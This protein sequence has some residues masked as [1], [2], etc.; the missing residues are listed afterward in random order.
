MGDYRRVGD[1]MDMLQSEKMQI[2]RVGS[3]PND[4]T[5]T[6]GNDLG[7][8]FEDEVFDLICIE[9]EHLFSQGV[10]VFHTPRSG[11]G[12]KDI[13]VTSNV[14]LSFLNQDF[15]LKG[16]ERIVIYIECKSSEQYEV[17]HDKFSSN[18]FSALEAN[19][20]YFV[21][22]TNATISPRSHWCTQ[23]ELERSGIDFRLVDRFL[24]AM[25]FTQRHS[26]ISGFDLKVEPEATYVEYQCRPTVVDGRNAFKLY[27]VCRNYTETTR[28]GTLVLQTD[29]GWDAVDG[30]N[31]TM[32]KHGCCALETTIV[33]SLVED[34]DEVRLKVEIGAT[35]SWFTLNS[36]WKHVFE[37][38]F[39]GRDKELDELRT[40]VTEASGCSA[41]HLFG[42]AGI[43]KSRLIS[44]AYQE[45]LGRTYDFMFLTIKRSSAKINKD[46][47]AFLTSK[48]YL[49]QSDSGISLTHSIHSSRNKYR[50]AIIVV[51][52]LHNA[53]GDFL[54]EVE[55]VALLE[56]DAPVG[57]L[58]CGR[59]DY[60]AFNPVY[61][62]HLRWCEDFNVPALSVPKLAPKKTSLLVKSLIA[63]VPEVVHEKICQL[64]NN[65]PL[66][67]VQFVEYLLEERIATI[68]GRNTIGITNINA[69]NENDYIPTGVEDI[70][71]KRLKYLRGLPEKDEVFDFLL[72]LTE[73]DG[74]L[75][76][77]ASIDMFGEYLAVPQFLEARRIIVSNG[78][79]YEFVHESM[80][81]FFR[82]QLLQTKRERVRVA[83]LVLGPRYE[84]LAI[85]NDL[86]AGKLCYWR[87]DREKARLHFTPYVERLESIENVS[88]LRVD[89]RLFEYLPT[90]YSYLEEEQNDI[91]ILKKIL[92]T[93]VYLAL[94][95]ISPSKAITE[96]NEALESIARNKELSADCKIKHAIQAQK[97][98]ALMM[99]GRTS[100]GEQVL[101][102][103]LSE[104]LLHPDR[105][106][107]EALFDIFDRLCV[108]SMKRN[109]IAPAK[110]Y[111]ELSLAI[112]KRKKDQSLEIIAH[113]TRTKLYFYLSKDEARASFSFVNRTIDGESYDR[114]K[115]CNEIA[116][117]I[118][119]LSF[120]PALCKEA[121]KDGDALLAHAESRHYGWAATRAYLLLA[122]C[123]YL[124]RSNASCNASK[125][126]ISK[127]INAC[128]RFSISD[129]IWQFYNL[130]G[131][132]DTSLD[133]EIAQ[134][135][136]V[137]LT[138]Y[139][140]LKHQKLLW[141]GEGEFCY[142]S[143][144][145]LN[146][147]GFF[148]ASKGL[149]TEFFD[150]MGDIV[151]GYRKEC[152]YDCS[153][154]TC[155]FVCPANL[156][157]LKR[158]YRKASKH[159]LLFMRQAPQNALR[160]PETDYF[161]VLG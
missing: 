122:T 44:E 134:I 1:N 158:A 7:N 129:S 43:G 60:D 157:E 81:L 152:D 50:R 33:R 69:F 130:L 161:I 32:E 138:V 114:I 57:I 139:A 136:K 62:S 115:T 100:E 104:Y 5:W 119:A 133:F 54:K 125:E 53:D 83:C 27:F 48:G 56:S 58:F 76:I 132:V 20:D 36:K 78:D 42:E 41:L 23:N 118:H 84:G 82:R 47:D 3:N 142:G 24:L 46:I 160:D 18:A 93:R 51:D 16:K 67:I 21:L 25:Y 74:R 2:Y 77:E 40:W 39:I 97:A 12:G 75:N 123:G 143:P 4:G 147:I 13:V 66:F 111:N 140:I 116:E 71:K 156:D 73:F 96:C 135:K 131:I 59:T 144:L 17:R 29:R 19:P 65:N 148:L 31:F 15:H 94:H 61:F 159:E 28:A 68:A 101:H 112:S 102:E 70:Y 10:R 79:H 103:L 141:T 106:G 145:A 110:N 14:P 89:A 120:D 121:R 137:F 155:N 124:E 37:P 80:L 128:I 55:K 87:G 98:H 91:E 113:R 38:R 151:Y 52:D 146:N 8:K 30:L 6:L 107:D 86:Q 49:D 64:S 45:L 95:H 126:H 63:G 150:V 117:L 11:D 85:L 108:A 34:I 149:E 9:L 154:Q 35:S 127:G 105:F 92:T 153:N 99:T 88:N 109:D 22:V 26:R 72:V 90:I